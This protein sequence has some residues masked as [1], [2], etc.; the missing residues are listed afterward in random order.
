MGRILAAKQA[1]AEAE[2]A[3]AE[4]KALREEFDLLGPAAIKAAEAYASAAGQIAEIQIDSADLLKVAN[5]LA[6]SGVRG[7]EDALVKLT[8]EGGISFTEF[9]NSIVADLL[10]IIYRATITVAILRALGD[11]GRAGLRPGKDYWGESGLAGPH[12]VALGK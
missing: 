6:E 5:D 12:R 8:T 3:L 2:R 10:R 4:T 1:S 11:R 7:I 9:A